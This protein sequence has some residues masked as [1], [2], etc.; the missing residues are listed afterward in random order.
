M[1]CVG[2]NF[3]PALEGFIPVE[4]GPY[5]WNGERIVEKKRMEGF[6][7]YE[8]PVERS[9]HESGLQ[10]QLSQAESHQ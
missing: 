8:K 3:V 1:I 2:Q 7:Q 5:I 9:L 10:T 6:T 4:V